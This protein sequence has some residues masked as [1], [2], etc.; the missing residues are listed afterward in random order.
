LNAGVVPRRGIPLRT[1]RLT[2]RR[3]TRDDITRFTAY[4]NLPEVWRYQDWTIPYT[5]DHAHDLLDELESLPGPTP[6][7]WVQL[8]IDDGTG[9]VGD[10]AV[11]ISPDGGLGMVGYTLDPQVQGRGYATEAVGAV[12]TLL[13]DRFRVHRVAAT[14]DPA[15]IAS[16]RV[17]ERLGFRYE[18]RGVRAALVRG[19]W[20]DDDRYALL[21]SEHRAWA[22]RPRHPPTVVE[23]VEVTADNV[24]EVLALETHLSQRPFVATVAESLADALVPPVEDG[25]SVVPWLRAVRA[26]GELA[27]FVMVTEVTEAHPVPM[28]WRLLIDRA[29]QGRGLGS[30]VV[31][32]VADR[33]RSQG[34]TRLLTSWVEGRGGPAGFYERLGFVRTGEI[35][36]DETFGELRLDPPDH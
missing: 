30:A 22:D 18:G 6:G 27:G 20:E 2:V 36:D 21:E 26:D 10:V 25:A 14:L 33:L 34:V 32:Q 1:R 24:R 4:R 8:A 5:R 35:I 15:N 29:H 13:F 23:L 7:A 11:W 9:L 12:V 16:A 31:L 3:F 28:L 17:L 19:A